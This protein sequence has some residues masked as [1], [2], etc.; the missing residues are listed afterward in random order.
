MNN[1]QNIQEGLDEARLALSKLEGLSK[2]MFTWLHR[3][4]LTTD[5]IAEVCGVRIPPYILPTEYGRK[6]GV[7]YNP[8]C[9]L[10]MLLEQLEAH[11]DARL[12]INSS[13]I[14]NEEK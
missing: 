13:N 3:I 9:R 4:D 6:N 12:S 7:R 10:E 1:Y 5:A 2:E 14:A 11:E 8:A